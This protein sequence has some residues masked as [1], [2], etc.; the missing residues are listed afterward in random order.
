VG[1]AVRLLDLF[2]RRQLAYELLDDYDREPISME[3]ALRQ[4]KAFAASGDWPSCQNPR[5]VRSWTEATL[6]KASLYR[7]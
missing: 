7:D 6:E 4:I 1:E 5:A 3:E 2:R